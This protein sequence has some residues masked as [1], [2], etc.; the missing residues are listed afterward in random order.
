MATLTPDQAASG[1]GDMCG[2]GTL[3]LRN[4]NVLNPDGTIKEAIVPKA[5]NSS[6]DS[7]VAVIGKNDLSEAF[8]PGAGA[9]TKYQNGYVNPFMIIGTFPNADPATC[10]YQWKAEV[11]DRSWKIELVNNRWQVTKLIQNSNFPNP[12]PDG[13]DAGA[14]DQI[15]SANKII[16]MYD[17]PGVDIAS[18]NTVIGTNSYYRSERMLKAT[19]LYGH[20]AAPTNVGPSISIGNVVQVKRVGSTGVLKNDYQA[21]GNSISQGASVDFK[22]TEQEVRDLVGGSLPIDIPASANQ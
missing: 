16:C 4:D 14:R 11:T 18:L 17:A 8:V 10:N 2:S 3:T 20:D 22:I 6:Y 1:S 5:D 15:L 9:N 12:N 13:P 7:E 19:V 21:K